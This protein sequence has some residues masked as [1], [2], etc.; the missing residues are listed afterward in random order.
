MNPATSPLAASTGI[1]P[2][3]LSS[4]K[5]HHMVLPPLLRI[6]STDLEVAPHVAHGLGAYGAA[7]R[8]LAVGLEASRVQKV[9]AGQLVHGRRRSE[10]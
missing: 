1:A 7:V 3:P 2:S 10:A 4:T 6:S 9:A 5:A 8:V